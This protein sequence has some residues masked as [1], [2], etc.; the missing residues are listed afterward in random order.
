MKIK[1]LA[2]FLLVITQVNAQF[3]PKLD[4]FQAQHKDGVVYLEWVLSSG[5]V[6]YGIKIE[7]SEDSVSFTEIGF[8]GG[9]CGNLTQPTVYNFE[10]NSP[11]LNKKM[12][13]RLSYPGLGSSEIIDV[14]VIHVSKHDYEANPT[15]STGITKLNF[16]NPKSE[17]HTL[18][19][20]N[21]SGVVVMELTSSESFFEFDVNVLDPGIYQFYIFN[22]SHSNTVGGRIL[23]AR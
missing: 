2:F 23:V 17:F 11:I 10:D 3:A 20:S 9:I 19:V 22:E 14:L 13:Y 12:Y 8:I 18:M 21:L 15:P 16:Y 6:C 4:K 1:V 7:R 5:S